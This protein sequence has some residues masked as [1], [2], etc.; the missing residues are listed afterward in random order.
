MIFFHSLMLTYPYCHPQNKEELLTCPA[1]DSPT[2]SIGVG[3]VLPSESCLKGETYSS[4]GC[5]HTSK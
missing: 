4:I 2:S 3:Y 1:D 5:I